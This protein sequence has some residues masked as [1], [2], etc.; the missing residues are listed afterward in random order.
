MVSQGVELDIAEHVLVAPATPLFRVY[1][2]GRP[3]ISNSYSR[4]LFLTASLDPE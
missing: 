3:T 1:N 2:N 4:K